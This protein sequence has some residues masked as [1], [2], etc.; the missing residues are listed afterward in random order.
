MAASSW[1]ALGPIGT[2]ALGMLL[3]GGDAP[4][5]FAANGLPGIGEIAAGL[6]LVAGSPCGASACGGC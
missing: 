4:A 6:G 5:I 2:G 1:L 3:L